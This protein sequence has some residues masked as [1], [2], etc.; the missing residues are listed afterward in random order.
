[1]GCCQSG[2]VFKVYLPDYFVYNL[3]N[4]TERCLGSLSHRASLYGCFL[5]GAICG[6][7]NYF[8]NYFVFLHCMSLFQHIKRFQ[9]SFVSFSGT[10]GDLDKYVTSTPDL[11]WEDLWKLIAISSGFTLRKYKYLMA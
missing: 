1:M 9:V 10:I 4:F 11:H 3:I 2:A 7:G 6:S 8:G 5:D